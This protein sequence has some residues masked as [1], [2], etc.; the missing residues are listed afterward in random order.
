MI[1]ST[2]I[3]AIACLVAIVLTPPKRSRRFS[4]IQRSAYTESRI[5]A[6]EASTAIKPPAPSPGEPSPLGSPGHDLDAA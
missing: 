5:G 2:D 3:L 6:V 4:R 1:E